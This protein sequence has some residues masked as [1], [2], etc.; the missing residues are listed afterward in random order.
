MIMYIDNYS[1]SSLG[2]I[3][4]EFIFKMH[5]FGIRKKLEDKNKKGKHENIEWPFP[6]HIRHQPEITIPPNRSR[7]PCPKII[8]HKTLSC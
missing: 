5:A 2:P 1:R 4:I 3:S 8:S 7:Y 6:D